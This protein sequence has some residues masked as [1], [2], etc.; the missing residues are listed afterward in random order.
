M[1]FDM[2]PRRVWSGTTIPGKKMMRIIS[3][4]SGV[5]RGRQLLSLYEDELPH[6][7]MFA[8][9][10][11]LH[12]LP[13][14]GAMGPALRDL[15]KPLLAGAVYGAILTD[16]RDF[17]KLRFRAS[18]L[19]EAEVGSGQAVLEGLVAGRLP[20]GVEP[21]RPHLVVNYAIS[22]LDAL[23]RDREGKTDFMTARRHLRNL[24]VATSKAWNPRRD[25]LIDNNMDELL[26]QP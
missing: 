13:E 17:L 19:S 5:S 23:S 4:V 2:S 21:M 25:E 10:C 24:L 18:G 3:S 20:E 26:E 22:A 7:A 6:K 9:A 12:E 1:T 8:A 16:I 15:A 14:K 11:A